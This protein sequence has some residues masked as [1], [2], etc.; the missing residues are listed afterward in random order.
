SDRIMNL[1]VI[2]DKDHGLTL[3][4]TALPSQADDVVAQLEADGLSLSDVKQIVLT[5]QDLDHVGA[6]NP[7]KDRTGATV[8]AYVDEVP[9]IDGTLRPIK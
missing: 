6:L 1:S 4:D 2:V 3:V 5:H 8:Y 7:L 9:Y